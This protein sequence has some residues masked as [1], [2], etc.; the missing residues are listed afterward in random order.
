MQNSIDVVDISGIM[1]NR[2]LFD[3][4]NNI[5]TNKKSSL[6]RCINDKSDSNINIEKKINFEDP[7][8]KKLDHKYNQKISIIVPNTKYYNFF[9]QFY[10]IL[11]MI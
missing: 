7:K 10:K 3:S 8:P 4:E 11:T 5:D 9:N 6:I 2:H 1:K